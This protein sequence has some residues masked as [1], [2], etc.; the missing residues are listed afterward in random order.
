MEGSG[1]C[2]PGYHVIRVTY[3][4]FTEEP[5][6]LIAHIAGVLDRR[7]LTHG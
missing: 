5:L 2:R 6:A 3:C 7:S 1:S 4:E